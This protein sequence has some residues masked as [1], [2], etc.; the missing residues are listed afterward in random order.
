VTYDSY[1]GCRDERTRV[2]LAAKKALTAR[3]GATVERNLVIAIRSILAPVDPVRMTSLVV[4]WHN[5]CGRELIPA[6]SSPVGRFLIARTT[7]S[8][9]CGWAECADAQGSHIPDAE[10]MRDLPANDRPRLIVEKATRAIDIGRETVYSWRSTDE[11]V[12]CD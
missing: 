8:L 12:K 6:D 1:S 10:T 5:A 7:S 9:G 4:S 11:S 3:H 2:A